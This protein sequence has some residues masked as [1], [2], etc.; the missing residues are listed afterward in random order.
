MAAAPI[1]A[2][3]ASAVGAGASVIGGVQQEKARQAADGEAGRQ[4]KKR[5][6]MEAQ[7]AAKLRDEET[8]TA[9]NAER[10][11]QAVRFRASRKTGRS[12]TILTSPL[13]APAAG[14]PAAG[15]TLLGA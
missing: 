5:A 4:A 13:G 8:T 1:L 9:A 6:D 15:K 11:S 3:I 14:S 12:G 7:A 10:E 2:A